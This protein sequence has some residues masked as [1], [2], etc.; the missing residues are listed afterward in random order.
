M[1][2]G[3]GEESSW[4]KLTA[5]VPWEGWM[6]KER[7]KAIKR[8]IWTLAGWIDACGLLLQRRQIERVREGL[9]ECRERDRVMMSILPN[10]YA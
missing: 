9:D 5:L 1:L 4:G 3:G 7:T 6:E 2:D 10:T 8:S